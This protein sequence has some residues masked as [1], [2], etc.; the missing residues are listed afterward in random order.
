MKQKRGGTRRRPHGVSEKEDKHFPRWKRLRRKKEKKIDRP[1]EKR[2]P[3]KSGTRQMSRPSR[4]TKQRGKKKCWWR[5]E[6]GKRKESAMGKRKKG[7]CEKWGV[8]LELVAV[9]EK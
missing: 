8:K 7:T 2:K 3:K 4:F 6:R 9:P 5:G 1:W